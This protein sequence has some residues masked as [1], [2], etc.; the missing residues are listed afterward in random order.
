MTDWLY[1][2]AAGIA[3]ADHNLPVFGPARRVVPGGDSAIAEHL[4]RATRYPA[5]CQHAA[6][7]LA[8]AVA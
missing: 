7:C 5:A 3:K 6:S 2:T 4:V 1:A 8:A